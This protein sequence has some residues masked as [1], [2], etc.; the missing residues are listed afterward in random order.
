MTNSIK[1]A[2][3]ALC[4][5]TIG[6]GAYAAGEPPALAPFYQFADAI[7]AAD[8]D[9]A[10]ALFTASSPLIDEFGQHVWNSFGDWQHDWK[11]YVKASG[12]SDVRMQA[13]APS[14]QNIDAQHGYGVVPTTLSFK[15][16]GKPQ[17]EK[18]LFTFSTAKTPD[19]WR[20]SSLTWS[21]L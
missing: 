3:A 17:T 8:M 10:A 14:F 1:L 7:N 4:V 12:G 18:G 2:V 6:S 21:T 9:K 19:G 20:I 15:I 5:S 16:K 11:A 13:S